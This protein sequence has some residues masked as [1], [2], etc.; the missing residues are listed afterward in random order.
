MNKARRNELSRIIRG[1]NTIQDKEDLY[2]LINE[3]ESL[4]DEE[5]D[6]YDNIPENLQN[7]QRAQDSEQAIDNL[8]EALDLLNEVYDA[9]DIDDDLIQQA[10][11]KIEDARF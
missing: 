9:N 2:S 4:K 6:Y 10:I 7:S 8:E 11:D 5:Q 3:L 1:L